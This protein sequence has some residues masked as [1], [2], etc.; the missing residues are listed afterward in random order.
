M[1]IEYK[2]RITFCTGNWFNRFSVTLFLPNKNTI[3]YAVSG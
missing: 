2:Y 3:K 1:Q